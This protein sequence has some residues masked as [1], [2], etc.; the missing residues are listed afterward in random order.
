MSKPT[1][2]EDSGQSMHQFSLISLRCLY[3]ERIGLKLSTE[4]TAKALVKMG[5]C[6]DFVE[7]LMGADSLFT[8]MCGDMKFPT[9]WYVRPAKLRPACANAQS[10]QSH[11]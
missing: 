6:A 8:F 1:R 7:F 2:R 3:G 5:G 9:I 10:D 4:L 11:C